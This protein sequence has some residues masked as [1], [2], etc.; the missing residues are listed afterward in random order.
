MILKSCELCGR[1]YSQVPY[2]ATKSKLHPNGT[3]NLCCD[4]VKK[5]LAAHESDLDFANRLCQWADIPF[6]VNQWIKLYEVNREDT[7]SI[8]FTIYSTKSRDDVNW[9]AV[10]AEWKKSQ[11][12]GT[13]SEK[14]EVL[15]DREYAALRTKWGPNYDNEELDYLEQ[16]L[17]GI[18]QTQVVNGKLQMD[19]AL[20]ICKISLIIDQKIRA[21]EN[22]KDD[23]ANYDKLV[24]TADFTP[25]NVKNANDF[26]SAG[27]IFAFLEKSGW[28]N[29]YYD[30]AE[31]DIVDKTMANIQAWIR[32]LYINE[33]GI[34]EDVEK[35][36]EGLKLA[37]ELEEQ[38]DMATEKEL[39]E[40]DDEAYEVEEF[41]P[42][43]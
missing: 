31:K 42:E 20:K 4:C 18:L 23:L 32:H 35:R 37:K 15:S 22:F 24:K 19:Q 27:E 43:I 33:T 36:I 1:S 29:K 3:L 34:A 25:S 28:V 21:G 11:E 9:R 16:L 41:I 7:F 12:E 26:D 40:F 8:Y 13:L 2:F 39:E 10:N 17:S 30:G 38:E 14:I 5:M 6:D